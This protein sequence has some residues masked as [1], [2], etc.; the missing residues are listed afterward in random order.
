MR[1]RRRSGCD[2][3][4]EIELERERE[5]RGEIET[6]VIDQ[7]MTSSEATAWI[8]LLA[9]LP[10]RHLTTLTACLAFAMQRQLIHFL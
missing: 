5:R 10:S 1:R 9:P 7:S 8:D 4:R 2:H 3:E 6:H